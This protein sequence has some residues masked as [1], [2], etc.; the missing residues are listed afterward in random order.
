MSLYIFN[1]KPT[2]AIVTADTRQSISVNGELY[3]VHDNA[4][5]LIQVDDMIITLGGVRFVC[6]YIMGQWER[7]NDRSIEN[8]REITLR[9]LP[10]L[11][12]LA[13]KLRIPH[14]DYLGNPYLLEFCLLRFD[15][16]RGC[17][18]FYQIA[19]SSG[20]NLVEFVVDGRIHPSAMI[21]GGIDLHVV[22]EYFKSHLVQV[23]ADYINAVKAAYTLATSEKIG[24]TL[25]VATQNDGETTINI[26]PLKDRYDVKTYAGYNGDLH[27][28]IGQNLHISCPDVNGDMMQVKID[29]QGFFQYNGRNYFQSDHGGKLGQDAHWGIF[30]GTKDLFSVTDTGYVRPSFAGDDGEVLLDDEGFPLNTNFLLGIDGDAYFRGHIAMKSGTARGVFE[31]QDF[32]LPN[33]ETFTSI[34]NGENKIKGDYIDA[35]GVR[36]NDD[37]GDPVLYMDATGIHWTPKYSPF[38][39]QFAT[40]ASGPWHD[41]QQTNDEYRRDSTDGGTTWG[42]PYKYVAKDGQNGRDGSDAAVPRYI[43]SVGITK[44]TIESP[45]IT[46]G[47]IEGGALR[48]TGN[49]LSDYNTVSELG[50]YDKSDRK[51]GFIRYDDTGDGGPTEA[52]ER[53]FIATE[54][55]KALKIESGGNLSITAQNGEGLIYLDG[56]VSFSNPPKVIAVFGE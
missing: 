5:K 36:I 4:Q 14:E 37:N 3:K 51:Y 45:K 20:Y 19:T 44:T 50:I 29:S 39:S 24:G 48:V 47:L 7:S 16:A 22:Q 21:Y 10:T 46:G 56:N 32:K 33:G 1:V 17:N 35:K 25:M 54:P 2:S 43:T 13:D 23:Q 11:N 15:P 28:V 52:R 55:G 30:G 40:S 41:A 6:E 34:L 53:M 49:I 8:L 31:A 38:K 9:L 18:V 42:A 27:N 26:Y 12:D